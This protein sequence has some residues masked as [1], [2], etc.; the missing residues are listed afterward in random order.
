MLQQFSRRDLDSL[1]IHTAIRPLILAAESVSCVSRILIWV[2]YCIWKHFEQCL[3]TS[4][5]YFTEGWDDAAIS[6]L[7]H[8]STKQHFPWNHKKAFAFC[9]GKILR[10][11][12][13][14]QENWDP[15]DQLSI[16]IPIL[17]IIYCTIVSVLQSRCP[18]LPEVLSTFKPV[19]VVIVPH[20]HITW[21]CHHVILFARGTT[22][23]EAL[24][25]FPEGAY[26]GC[27]LET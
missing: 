8:L 21:R 20:E 11:P 24:R 25:R 6:V 16:H 3:Q 26:V 1:M 23:I 19:S 2:G 5:R 15:V 12:I 7:G 17:L 9:P 27:P 13:A 14:T 22:E 4:H 18:T 10:L